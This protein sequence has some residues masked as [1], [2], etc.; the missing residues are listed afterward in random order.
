MGWDHLDGILCVAKPAG[1]TSH[2]VVARLRRL[3]PG[4]RLGHAGTLDPSASGVLVVCVGAYT[5]LAELFTDTDKEYEG[6]VLFGRATDTLDLDGATVARA[7]V[8][9]RIVERVREVIPSFLGTHSQEVPAYSAA[10][11]RGTPLYRWARAGVVPPPRAKE[12]RL[13]EAEVWP[14]PRSRRRVRF[15]V[16]TGTGF[17]VRA[18]VRDLGRAIGVPAVL[19]RLC[20]TRVGPYDLSQAIPLERAD[21]SM[22]AAHLVRGAEAIPWLPRAVVDATTFRRLRSGASHEWA[23]A[24]GLVAV[25]DEGGTLGLIAR[26]RDGLL[27]PH[28]VLSRPGG[29]P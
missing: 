19:G 25:V 26:A 21:R 16:V 9:D 23:I 22:I 15:R 2:D 13:F 24:D 8:P 5:R 17:Y 4:N 28:I 7:R 12:V 29:H 6:V 10:K 18:W 11:W 20:R 3:L 1:P 14:H 27:H